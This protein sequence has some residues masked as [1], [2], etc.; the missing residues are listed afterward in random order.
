MWGKLSFWI[1]VSVFLFPFV[2]HGLYYGQDK[3]SVVLE[4]GE[5]N[6][7][8]QLANGELW[9]YSGDISLTFDGGLLVRAR[10]TDLVPAPVP[11][12][13]IEALPDKAPPVVEEPPAEAQRVEN[14]RKSSR[15][16]DDEL[17]ETAH[18]ISDP[19]AYKKAVESMEKEFS[20]RPSSSSTML[21][22]VLAIAVPTVLQ[23]IFLMI[24]FKWVGAE[25][26]KSVLL[27]IAFIDRLVIIAVQAVFFN[28]LEYP[29]TFHADSLL[30]FAIMLALVT[31]FTHAKQLPTAI[32]VVIA[33]KV[34]G[35]I[36]A[37]LFLLLI[38]HNL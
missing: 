15:T 22:R 10:G 38:L 14:K 16:E 24:A 35:F 19:E 20:S 33:S 21:Q 18:S 34:A 28:F 32:K 27:L 31:S 4:M 23:W 30:S 3:S 1:L 36:A 2:S 37:Y 29:T 5:P 17:L 6:G 26:M 7:K 8:R 25:A 11:E 9:V 12:V 13:L